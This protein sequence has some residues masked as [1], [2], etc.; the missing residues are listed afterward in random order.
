MSK[1][2]LDKPESDV[3][4]NSLNTRPEEQLHYSHESFLKKKV[5][6]KIN[7]AGK[8]PT[9]PRLLLVEYPDGAEGRET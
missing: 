4:E 3:F 2:E 8:I 1:R 9:A 5:V 7:S 6:V